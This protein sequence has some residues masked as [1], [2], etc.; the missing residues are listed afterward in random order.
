MARRP[1]QR[2]RMAPGTVEI[3]GR[4]VRYAVS[5]NERIPFNG[6]APQVW[7]VNIHGYFA[8]GGMYWRESARLAAGLD[9]RVVNPSLPG[10]GGS[11]PLPWDD[12]AMRGFSDT[13]ARLLDHLGADRAVILG[14]SMGGAVAVQFAHDHPDRTLGV[15]YRD[16]AATT[17]WKERRSVLARLVS[18]VSPDLAAMV[19]LVAAV[20]V[21]MPDFLIGRIRSTLRGVMPDARKNL[22]SVAQALPVAALLFACDLSAEVAHIAR[23]HR[24]P[25]LPVWGRFDR[26]TPLETAD[27][28]ERISGREVHYVRGGH[29][30][31]IARPGT[32]LAI[33]RHTDRG[34]E[35]VEAVG[36][37]S[38]PEGVTSI[39]RG[40]PGMAAHR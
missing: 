31:M 12:L 8:G 9:W 1:D 37:G 27:E 16:G 30:W 24:V 32:Q 40:L 33:L 14:H 23:E 10:F 38:L 21:D 25:V 29:S 35:F 34:Q 15:V 13:I 5:D 26:I 3:D 22:A 2:V 11:D 36:S 17:S 4:Q 20:A 7:A 19:D 39:S 18:P 28:F 6:A